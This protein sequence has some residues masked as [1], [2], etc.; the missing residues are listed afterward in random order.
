LYTV[1]ETTAGKAGSGGGEE[2]GY[3]GD[4]RGGEPEMK[5]TKIALNPGYTGFVR[6]THELEMDNVEVLL[7]EKRASGKRWSM[8]PTRP[9]KGRGKRSSSLDMCLLSRREWKNARGG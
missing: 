1:P 7:V 8:R 9:Q 6:E 3:S 4:A 5:V 2:A